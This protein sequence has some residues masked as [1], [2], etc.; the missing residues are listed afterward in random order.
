MTTLQSSDLTLPRGRWCGTALPLGGA[1][2][3]GNLYIGREDFLE[4]MC[5]GGAMA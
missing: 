3:P 1:R 4:V 5:D 2:K